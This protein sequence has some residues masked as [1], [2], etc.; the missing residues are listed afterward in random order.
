MII[1]TGSILTRAETFE[2]ARRLGMEHSRRSR[3]EP[4]CLSHDLHVDCETPLKLVFVE[5]WA[6]ADALKAHFDVA[7]SVD[8]VRA[9]RGLAAERTQ[10]TVY[11]A[12][13]VR[14]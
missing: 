1:V 6:D 5:R 11:E 10:M 7:A 9:V 8:F 4:G 12:E 13:K 14:V 2:A 3:A